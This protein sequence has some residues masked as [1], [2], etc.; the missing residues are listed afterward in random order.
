MRITMAVDPG[1]LELARKLSGARSK[2]EAVEVA[3]RE[4]VHRRAGEKLLELEGSGIVSMDLEEL[5]RC[6]VGVL[7]DTAAGGTTYPEW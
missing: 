4:Y 6:R 5:V 1:L 3:L 2:R 7:A